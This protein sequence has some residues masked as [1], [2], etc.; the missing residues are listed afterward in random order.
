MPTFAIHQDYCKPA[1]YALFG[2][3]NELQVFIDWP[4]SSSDPTETYELKSEPVQE[5]GSGTELVAE[6]EP[7]FVPESALDPEPT[8]EPEPDPEPEPKFPEPALD[9]EFVPE[10]EFDPELEPDPELDVEL[11]PE[12]DPEVDPEDD[13]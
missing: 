10:P 9:P 13:E 2:D 6:P 4:T 11:E 8:L 7:E 12:P 3:T 5:L 1:I